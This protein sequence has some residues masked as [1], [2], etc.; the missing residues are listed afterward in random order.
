MDPEFSH[1]LH[2]PPRGQELAHINTPD[3]AKTHPSHLSGTRVRRYTTAQ[4]SGINSSYERIIELPPTY[5]Q[6]DLDKESIWTQPLFPLMPVGEDAGGGG[7]RSRSTRFG[8]GVGGSREELSFP[9]CYS[10][11]ALLESRSRRRTKDKPS[12][13]PQWHY[14]DLRPVFNER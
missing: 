6:N 13:P 2:K 7:G 11:E 12:K 8:G 1:A 14:K 3:W 9:P 5:E 4:P 10:Y